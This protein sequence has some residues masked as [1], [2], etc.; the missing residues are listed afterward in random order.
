M[1][2]AAAQTITCGITGLSA[3]PPITWIGPDDNEISNSDTSNYVISQSAY[4]VG[5]KSSFLTIKTG[6]L[7][8]LS[9]A[10]VFKCK[11]KS[12]AYPTDS[13]EVVKAMTLTLLALGMLLVGGKNSLDTD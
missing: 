4:Q 8:T 5:S 9:V 7:S 12:A 1:T 10:S 2:T 13:P 3:E 6:K 11:L